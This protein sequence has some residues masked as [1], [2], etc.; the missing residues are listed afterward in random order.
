MYCYNDWYKKYLQ[1]LKLQVSED[2]SLEMPKTL[3]KMT[4]FSPEMIKKVEFYE[5]AVKM[6]FTD[7]RVVSASAKEGDKYDPEFGMMVCILKY[8]WG[9]SK[10]LTDFQK[11]IKKA[12]QEKKEKEAKILAEKEAK[13]RAA[14]KHA[15]NQLRLEKRKAKAKE[16]AIEIQK[17]AYK[18]ALKELEEKDKKGGD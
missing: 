17:E 15:K 12:E 3:K 6:T 1:D 18:R 10:Y 8:L 9:G 2:M 13:E 16:E 7:G 14:K 5:P 11:W 4:T